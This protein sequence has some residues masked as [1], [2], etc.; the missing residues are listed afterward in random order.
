M[1]IFLTFFT[2]C[3]FYKSQERDSDYHYAH[4][5]S[6][7]QFKHGQDN[8]RTLR[9]INH[10][11]GAALG[12]ANKLR[13]KLAELEEDNALSEIDELNEKLKQCDDGIPIWTELLDKFHR[14][15]A[16]Y[17]KLVPQ[18]EK[19]KIDGKEKYFVYYSN[20]TY[21]KQSSMLISLNWFLNTE[22]RSQ[23]EEDNGDEPETHEE[24]EEEEAQEEQEQGHEQEDETS[25]E[26]E[27]EGQEEQEELQEDEQGLEGCLNEAGNNIHNLHNLI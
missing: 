9:E 20:Q 17:E 6:I 24:D 21:N 4:F 19:K 26:D 10:Q 5:P 11:L 13:Q 3:H 12:R 18:G 14:D 25:E 7:F 15:K 8:E 27:E 22:T 23:A 2:F 16:A 1:K